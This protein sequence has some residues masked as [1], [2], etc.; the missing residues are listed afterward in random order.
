V[1]A[2]LFKSFVLTN[3]DGYGGNVKTFKCIWCLRIIVN[4]LLSAEDGPNEAP[5][6]LL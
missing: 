2:A 5:E 1:A 4:G 6:D 3:I